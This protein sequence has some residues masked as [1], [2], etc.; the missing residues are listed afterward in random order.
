MKIE[1]TSTASRSSPPPL[2]RRSSRMP[3]GAPAAK[4]VD[5]LAQEPVRAL[6]EGGELDDAELL[7]LHLD[8]PAFHH[9]HLDPRA[10]HGERPRHALV[11][12]D[13]LEP[14]LRARRALDARRGHAARHAGDRAPVHRGDELALLDPGAVGGRAVEDV[15][16][17]QAAA[18][19]VNVHPHA[20]ELAPDRLL[21]LLGL[22]WGEVVG[23]LVAEALDD[24]LQRALV[25]LRVLHRLVEVVL[26]Q[27]DDLGAKGA[28]VV[29]E[30]RRAPGPGSVSGWPPSQ[31]PPTAARARRR[32]AR[33]SF[34]AS[35]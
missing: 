8:D 6:A 7:A 29:D 18:I 21:E 24:P 17:L 32:S 19:L 27:V 10:A 3:C 33:L 28:V 14:H 35:P 34:R 2:P 1:D 26:D 9:R 22:L 30:R 23:E 11:G 20:L 5:L 12:I 31:I 15:D 4:P 13:D 16:H 25:D